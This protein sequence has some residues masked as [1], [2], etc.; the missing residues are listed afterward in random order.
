MMGSK[1]NVKRIVCL[2]NSRKLSGRCVAGKE[3][4]SERAS[5]WIRPISRRPSEELSLNE[6]K[7]E[8][9]SDPQL[10]D[11]IDITL[12]TANPVRISLRIGC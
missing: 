4:S 9:G 2:A 12:F 6:R 1:D 11:I 7:Y 3:L 10:L 8:D 5:T